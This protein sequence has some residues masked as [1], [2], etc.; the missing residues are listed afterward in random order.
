M[1]KCANEKCSYY[2][3]NFNNLSKD[4][5]PEEKHKYKPHYIYRKF[6]V[7]FFSMDLN[8]FPKWATNFKYR[9]QNIQ[10]ITDHVNLGL[11]L[12]KTAQALKDI[13]NVEISH[14][15]VDNYA[16]TV[17]AIKKPL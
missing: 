12:H 6:T 15:M 1:H 7:D 13:H 4:F 17:T 8:Q 14:T 3:R 11:S 5:P 16:R 2:K 10:S 9:K